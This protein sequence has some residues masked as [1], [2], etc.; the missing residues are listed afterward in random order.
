MANNNI[1]GRHC[2]NPPWALSYLI[3]SSKPCDFLTTNQSDALFHSN[4]VY[5]TLKLVYDIG[6]WYG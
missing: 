6:S 5:T 3:E 4:W 2:E 1:E